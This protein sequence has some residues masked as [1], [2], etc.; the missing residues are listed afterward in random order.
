MIVIFIILTVV[1]SFSAGWFVRD[2]VEA[3]APKR[4]SNEMSQISATLYATANEL[5]IAG[6]RDAKHGRVLLSKKKYSQADDLIDRAR[7]IEAKSQTENVSVEVPYPTESMGY[8]DT[9]DRARGYG[10]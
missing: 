1:I 4:E 9:P 8:V 6:S 3:P 10:L 2:F 7:K 5:Y